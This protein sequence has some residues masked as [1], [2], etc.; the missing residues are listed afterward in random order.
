MGEGR[1]RE[2]RNICE[3]CGLTVDKLKRVAIESLSIDDI[4]PGKYTFLTKKELL[5]ALGME[6]SGVRATSRR[7]YISNK[8]SIQVKKTNFG[9]KDLFAD[10]STFKKFRKSTYLDASKSLQEMRKKRSN[11]TT[12]PI[13]E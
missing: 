9:D 1:N 3:G 2:I 12:R 13:K 8:K 5:K 10:D 6:K 11:P 7:N 4:S